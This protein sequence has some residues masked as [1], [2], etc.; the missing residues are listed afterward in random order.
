[1]KIIRSG[2]MDWRNRKYYVVNFCPN[3][4][5]MR[6]DILRNIDGIKLRN[7]KYDFNVKL[8][9]EAESRGC[10][11]VLI[12]CREDDSEIIEYELRKAE[13][14]DGFAKWKEIKKG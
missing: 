13:R 11:Q 2:F 5:E 1:M 8:P 12:G 6:I 7:P 3:A 9:D 4:Y 14:N 10:Y